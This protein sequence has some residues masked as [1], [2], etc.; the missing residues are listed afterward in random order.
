MADLSAFEDSQFDVH[1]WVNEV[2][3]AAPSSAVPRSQRTV[4][5]GSGPGSGAGGDDLASVIMKLQLLAQDSTEAA[6]HV[7][8]HQ[9]TTDVAAEHGGRTD[10]DGKSDDCDYYQSAGSS[11]E[12]YDEWEGGGGRL[13]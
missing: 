1:Q 11:G 12:H 10:A 9:T 7:E 5:Q 8:G 4:Q 2:L 3:T 6:A 13:Y